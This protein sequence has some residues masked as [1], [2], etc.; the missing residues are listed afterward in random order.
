MTDPKERKVELAELVIEKLKIEID[1]KD[2]VKIWNDEIKILN[3]QIEKTAEI[4]KNHEA[5]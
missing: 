5:E 4:I 2:Q 1:K 3:D